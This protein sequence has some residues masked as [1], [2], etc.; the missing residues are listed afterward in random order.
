MKAKCSL[1]RLMTLLGNPNHIRNLRSVSSLD[2]TLGD[3][4][5][6]RKRLLQQCRDLDLI[7]TMPGKCGTHH[8]LVEPVGF[9]FVWQIPENG[10]FGD[11]QTKPN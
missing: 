7:A 8:N 11:N 3:H 5:P 9:D 6:A 4:P 10:I 1:H 2:R